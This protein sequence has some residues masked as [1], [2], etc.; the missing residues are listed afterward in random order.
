[1]QRIAIVGGR[2][3][4]A[5]GCRL[6]LAV[7]FVGHT[8]AGSAMAQ[9]PGPSPA[10]PDE[11][12]TDALRTAARTKLVEG[13]GLLKLG[14]YQDALAVFKEAFALFPSPKIHYNFG[15]ALKGMGRNAEALEAFDR[16]VA[17]ANDAPPDARARALASRDELLGRVGSVRVT[18]DV[19]GASILIDGREIGRTPHSNDI[20][21]DPGPH[22]LTVD[23]G[24]GLLP[25]TQRLEVR[26]GAVLPVVAR[27]PD[28]LGATGGGR[29]GALASTPGGAAPDASADVVRAGDSARQAPGWLRPAAWTAAGIGA[30]ALVTGAVS[31][32]IKESEFRSFNRDPAC[33]RGLPNDGGATCHDLLESGETARKVGIAGFIA[34]GAFGIASA[35]AF[36][37]SARTSG[38]VA[39]TA[40]VS[41]HCGV[42]SARLGQAWGASCVGRF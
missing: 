3:Q 4:H 28:A 24:G 16:F 29:E 41:F 8:V 34:A 35:A 42:E 21:L 11:V 20:R 7:A 9:S 39:G 25:F 13:D 18:T 17:E 10:V 6:A 19:T 30:A 36:V 5:Q 27:F 23:R 22:M 14:A 1:M 40:V 26:A 33:D 15:L 32:T 12:Q 38:S 37:A 2:R 31:W